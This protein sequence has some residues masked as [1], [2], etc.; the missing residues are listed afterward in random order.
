MKNNYLLFGTFLLG[1]SFLISCNKSEENI[2]QEINSD[3]VL[4][5]KKV[6]GVIAENEPMKPSKLDAFVKQTIQEK[7][8]F[9]WEWVDAFTLWSAA[10]YGENTIAIGYQPTDFK[11]IDK[12]IHTIDIQSKPWK[13]V[14]DALITLI[15]EEINKTATTPIKWEDLIVEDDAQLPI[16]TFRCNSKDVITKLYNLENVRY[17]EPMDYWP[18]DAQRS[19]SGCDASTTAL[20]SADWT[21]ITPGCRMPWNFV[22]CNIPNAWNISE[23]QGIT[24]GVIDAGINSTQTLLGSNFNNGFSAA[25]RTITTDFTL[26]TSAFTSCTHGT[27]MS[28][29]AV[30]PRNNI[31]NSTGVAYK[32]NLHFIRACND[33]VL[34]ASSERT[35]VKNALVRMGDRNAVRIISMSIGT[36]F[37]S[38]V[39][40]DG[41]NYAYNKGKLIFAAAGTSF[42]WTS[43]WGVIYPAAYSNCI[44]VTGVKEGGATCGTC[45]DGSEVDFTIPMER[46][47]NSDRNTLSLAAS[48][49]TPSYIGGSSS[50]TAT[51]AGIA[52]LVW[53]AKPTL[54]RDQVY[55]C[56]RNTSQF[57]PSINSSK[58]FGNLNAA[59]AVNLGLTY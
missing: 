39:L 49:N 13:Q 59:A 1:L 38:G 46:S 48:G 11:E 16:L 19:S 33:V 50:A 23:G 3:K 45:H 22:N 55:L 51:A 7:N 29:I 44:A 43:W 14:H 6:L 26:G 47:S 18:A 12:N 2:Q 9:K 58:G 52:A 34:D 25:S 36:P 42:S 57:Y 54:T 30:G 8:D 32:S 27:S 31:N 17:I 4:R 28:G 15:V 21:N 40:S 35:A 10:Q 20:N 24:V 37:S 41:V 5:Y 56:L 53:S